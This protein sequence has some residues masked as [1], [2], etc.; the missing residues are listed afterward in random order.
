MHRLLRNGE[1]HQLGGPGDRFVCRVRQFELDLVRT[2]FQSDEDHRFAARV[3]GRPRLVIHVVVQVSKTWRYR[4]GGVPKHRQDAQVFGP[5]LN[6]DAPLGQLLGNRWIDDQLRRRLVWDCDERR[7]SFDLLRGLCGGRER[8]QRDGDRIT[9]PTRPAFPVTFWRFAVIVIQDLLGEP[10]SVIIWRS[11][12]KRW[13]P[14]SRWGEELRL[15][16]EAGRSAPPSVRASLGK[17]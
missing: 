4:K 7:R 3:D 14:T 6:E 9:A 17:G 12:L 2:G 10:L 8:A 11:D 1:L 15:L 16:P 5:V 13:L